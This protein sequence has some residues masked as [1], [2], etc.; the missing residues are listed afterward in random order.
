MLK[1]SPTFMFWDLILR[2]KTLIL[3]FVRAH[4]EKKFPLYIGIIEE[5]MPQFFALDHVSYSRWMPV[6]IR[7]LKSLPDSIKDEFEKQ[8]H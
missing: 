2:L 8:C 7:D 6:H 4:R 3:I 1:T 5:L